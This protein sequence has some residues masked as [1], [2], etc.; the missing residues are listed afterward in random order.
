MYHDANPG[1]PGE[2]RARRRPER[3]ARVSAGSAAACAHAPRQ[4][5]CIY[6]K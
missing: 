6:L 1:V 3:V 2:L 5:Q 4:C